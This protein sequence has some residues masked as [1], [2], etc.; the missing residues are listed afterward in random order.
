VQG[1]RVSEGVA[2]ARQ[3]RDL[4]ASLG[5]TDLMAAIDRDLARLP[6]P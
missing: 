4:A 5:Q 2:I 6:Q 3:A 1:G